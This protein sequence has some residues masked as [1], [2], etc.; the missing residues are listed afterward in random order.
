MTA[1]NAV[2]EV[3]KGVESIPE[4]VAHPPEVRASTARVWI[5]GLGRPVVAPATIPDNALVVPWEAG[6]DTLPA[7]AAEALAELGREGEEG[8]GPWV[9]PPAPVLFDVGTPAG[10]AID[11]AG[12]SGAVSNWGCLEVGGG[13][14]RLDLLLQ[15]Y[16]RATFVLTSTS[17]LRLASDRDLATLAAAAG[18]TFVVERGSVEAAKRAWELPPHVIKAFVWVG[19]QDNDVRNV[20]SL[21]TSKGEQHED[22]EGK[23]AGRVSGLTDGSASTEIGTGRYVGDWVDGRPHGEGIMEW[24]NG[25]AYEGSWREGR[26]HGI[27][28]KRY[29]R[30]GG[31]EGEWV[32]GKR[33]GRGTTHYKAGRWEGTFVDNLADGAGTMYYYDSEGEEGKEATHRS[34]AFAAGKP[35]DGVEPKHRG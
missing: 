25:I 19:A 16:P 18:A 21:S 5:E 23:F 1:T 9:T 10:D 14:D 20:R 3:A 31:Y 4:K 15:R 12:W 30:G 35:L 8:D 17:A 34:F 6:N 2:G 27:G 28:I 24:D 29:S 26:F 32:D 11:T 13:E 7:I 22:M 33:H